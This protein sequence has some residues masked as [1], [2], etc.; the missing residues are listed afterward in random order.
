MLA[1]AYSELERSFKKIVSRL[2]DHSAYI[3]EKRLASII[4]NGL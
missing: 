2:Q 3:K 4:A 1:T